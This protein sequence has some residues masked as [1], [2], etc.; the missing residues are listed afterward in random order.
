M[1][2]CSNMDSSNIRMIWSYVYVI[3]FG[4]FKAIIPSAFS[5]VLQFEDMQ[6]STR[7]KTDSMPVCSQPAHKY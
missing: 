1:H 4:D 5:S 7:S 2:L 6:F 3:S